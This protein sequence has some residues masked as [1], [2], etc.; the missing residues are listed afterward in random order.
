MYVT[1]VEQLRSI[2]WGRDWLWDIKFPAAPAPFNTWF[3]ASDISFP[4]AIVSS[5]KIRGYSREYSAPEGSGEPS[6]SLTFFDDANQTLVDWFT[7][8]MRSINS[9]LYG[10]AL[11]LDDAVREVDIARLNPDR[12]LIKVGDSVY[13]EKYWVYPDGKLEFKGG[14]ANKGKMYSLDFVIVGS[15]IAEI[16]KPY[17][18]NMQKKGI[19]TIGQ[20]GGITTNR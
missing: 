10:Y 8:W 1:G 3:P 15:L 16:Q 19:I 18:L 9:D 11:T 13:E 20:N 12:S 4:T 14:S 17:L 7:F 5:Y 6:L 2:E